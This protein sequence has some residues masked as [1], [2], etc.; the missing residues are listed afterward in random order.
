MILR[1]DSTTPLG[2]PVVPLVYSITQVRRKSGS[3]PGVQFG[4]KAEFGGAA[5]GLDMGQ[6]VHPAVVGIPTCRA[7][8]YR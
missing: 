8:R 6:G 7:C 3:D 4:T 2:L 5:L 1:F